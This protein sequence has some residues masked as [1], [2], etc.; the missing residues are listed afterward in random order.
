MTS[1]ATKQ[2]AAATRLGRATTILSPVRNDALALFRR[3]DAAGETG[4][5]SPA[6]V[7]RAATLPPGMV[8]LTVRVPTPARAVRC[9]EQ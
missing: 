6:S 5:N 7:K 4:A 9:L 1:P 2:R 3:A 8:G